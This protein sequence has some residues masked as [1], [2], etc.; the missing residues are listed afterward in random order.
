[1]MRKDYGSLRAG[2]AWI[3]KGTHQPRLMRADLDRIWE[4]R[5]NEFTANLKIG[6][7]L[8]GMP[9]EVLCPAIGELQ[10]PSDQAAEKIRKILS[11]R[12]KPLP[13]GDLSFA[14]ELIETGN[15]PNFSLG[16]LPYSQ[17]SSKQL[18]ENLEKLKDT[19]REH[20]LH[21]LYEQHAS[22]IN[23]LILNEGEAYVEDA[24]IE[25]KV[26]KVN[27]LRVAP[28]IYTETDGSGV[29]GQPRASI[30][31]VLAMHYPTVKNYK[32]YIGIFQSVGTLRH[33]IPERAFQEP[34]RMVFGPELV[35]RKL[36]LECTLRGKQLRTPRK[37]TLVIE[38]T[39][40]RRSAMRRSAE[41][42]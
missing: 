15:F 26:L 28:K 7:D 3:R 2:D 30:Y 27:G 36:S 4:R 21:S 19:Y 1:M 23:V 18:Q 20:D 39:E 16:P 11:E 6:F 22:R 14:R 41:P 5:R 24:S 33:G 29:F 37:E 25:I 31:N 9:K 40:P 38:I 34:V 13:P 35:G 42:H 10:L 12:K 8:A 32:D 17:R